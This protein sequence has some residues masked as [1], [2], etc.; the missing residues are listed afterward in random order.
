MIHVGYDNVTGQF[1]VS[2]HFV[3]PSSRMILSQFSLS[4]HLC[5]SSILVKAFGQIL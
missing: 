3:L 4:S 2:L 5:V 1:T